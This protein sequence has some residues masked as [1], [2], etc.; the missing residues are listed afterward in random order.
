MIILF[1]TSVHVPKYKVPK[2]YTKGK[3]IEKSPTEWADTATKHGLVWRS[4]DD[5]WPVPDSGLNQH[6]NFI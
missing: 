3:L 2:T 6:P 1:D 4:A 5:L